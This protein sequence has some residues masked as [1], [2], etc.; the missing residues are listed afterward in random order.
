M[1]KT[2]SKQLQVI[3]QK[4]FKEAREKIVDLQR[5]VSYLTF[6]LLNFIYF[7]Q[8]TLYVSFFY[9]IRTTSTSISS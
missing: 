8:K 5:Q 2:K 1:A 9:L 3:L 4:D 6:Q 7:I